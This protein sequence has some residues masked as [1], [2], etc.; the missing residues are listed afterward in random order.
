MVIKKERQDITLTGDIVLKLREL[1]NKYSFNNHTST[2][3]MAI[4]KLYEWE[5][6]GKKDQSIE[7]IKELKEDIA[8]IKTQKS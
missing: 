1:T 3:S 7:L 5:I 4:T 2:I 8:K 6:N